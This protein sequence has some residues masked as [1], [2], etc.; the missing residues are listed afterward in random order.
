MCLAY[1]FMTLGLLHLF[2]FDHGLLGLH[3]HLQLLYHV[4]L[5]FLCFHAMHLAWAA[6]CTT[7]AHLPGWTCFLLGFKNHFIHFIES[8]LDKI[9]VLVSYV[10][11]ALMVSLRLSQSFGQPEI[12]MLLVC[13]FLIAF[14]FLDCPK[15]N[16]FLLELLYPGPIIS[17]VGTH[18]DILLIRPIFLI[19]HISIHSRR[20]CSTLFT[21][22]L[23]F[24]FP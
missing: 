9:I 1:L 12:I 19:Y 6:G 23:F 13:L 5:Q 21:L 4:L 11:I 18:H 2:F 8:A 10:N 14:R 15:I 16:D 17:T 20:A 3:V 7:C 24:K 22:L